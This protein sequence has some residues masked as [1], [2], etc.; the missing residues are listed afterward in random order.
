MEVDTL[1]YQGTAAFHA[2]IVICFVPVQQ[3]Y[4]SCC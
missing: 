3:I 4:Y 1:L 2:M